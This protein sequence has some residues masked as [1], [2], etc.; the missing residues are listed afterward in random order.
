MNIVYTL[1]L[2]EMMLLMERW[3]KTVKYYVVVA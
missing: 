3:A 1:V 2:L